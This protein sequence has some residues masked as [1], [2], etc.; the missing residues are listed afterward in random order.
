MGKAFEHATVWT[1]VAEIFFVG[2]IFYGWPAYIYVLKEEGVFLELCNQTQLVATNQTSCVEQDTKFNSIFITACLLSNVFGTVFGLILDKFGLLSGRI[3]T[4]IPMTIGLIMMIFYSN[5]LSLEFGTY[6]IAISAIGT[7]ITNLPLQPIWPKRTSTI[8]SIYSGTFDGSAA[9]FMLVKVCYQ[10]LNWP[11][12]LL[13]TILACLS[14]ISWLRTIFLMPTKILPRE[15]PPNY[16][17]S[18]ET[19]ISSCKRRGTIDEMDHRELQTRSNRDESEIGSNGEK[20]ME[21]KPVEDKEEKTSI[22]VQFKNE[23]CSWQFF[24]LCVWYCLVSLRI[25]SFQ[26]WFNN[27]LEWWFPGE[28]K[29]QSELTDIFGLTYIMSLPISPAAGAV[30]DFFAARYRPSGQELRGRKIG[31]AVVCALCTVLSTVLSLLCTIRGSFAI[32]VISQ[33]TFS[34]I[35][36]F[37]YAI[38]A[39]A[40]F[41]LFPMNLFG[42]I[43]GTLQLFNGLISL[44]AD[45]IFRMIHSD[46]DGDY[47]I[48][49]YA[50]SAGCLITIF[51]PFVLVFHK[52]QS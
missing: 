31:V 47:T 10:A 16:D 39:Q 52:K 4:A 37:I 41:L 14:S 24:S 22:F 20:T 50:L 12:A 26:A 28:A 32:S 49:H 44:T 51:Q 48:V 11:L 33:I 46:L 5:R 43:Y 21:E 9:T 34:V 38:L 18:N 2:G 42:M 3:F 15:L 1:G 27:S 7:L 30:V 13:S 36:T 45:P 8:G 17:L 35:R 29:I 40:A 19:L 23:I 6:L 25:N